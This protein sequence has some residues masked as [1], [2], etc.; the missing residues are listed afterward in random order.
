MAMM[1]ILH[2][3][4]NLITFNAPKAKF[5]RYIYVNTFMLGMRS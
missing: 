1:G 2:I 4:M 5:L 3:F